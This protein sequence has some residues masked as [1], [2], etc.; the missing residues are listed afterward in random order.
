MSGGGIDTTSVGIDTTDL[1][2][3]PGDHQDEDAHARDEIEGATSRDGEGDTQN[4]KAAGAPIAEEKSACP[5]P[6]QISGAFTAEHCKGCGFV[7]V[8]CA[9]VHKAN[10]KRGTAYA[11]RSLTARNGKVPQECTA[12][13]ENERPGEAKQ[14]ADRPPFGG[15]ALCPF[16][17]GM[18]NGDSLAY[19]IS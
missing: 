5:E 12:L 14:I 8:V 17:A 16:K 18:P 10:F 11:A 6:A 9:G 4:I 15:L 1:R 13:A 19:G 3:R 7:F 2:I